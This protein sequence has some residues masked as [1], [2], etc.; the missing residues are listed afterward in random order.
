MIELVTTSVP[1]H[2]MKPVHIQLP[3]KRRHV[4]VLEIF[5]QNDFL[6]LLQIQYLKRVTLLRLK[7]FHGS[8]RSMG[9]PSN[10]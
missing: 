6:K 8:H 5:W 7:G 9:T 2:L 4:R 3:Y 1:S 10:D